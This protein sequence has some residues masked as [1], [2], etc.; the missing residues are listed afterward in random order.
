MSPC[1]PFAR[2]DS[3][4][5]QSHECKIVPLTSP[6]CWMWC[7][8]SFGSPEQEQIQG[9]AHGNTPGTAGCVPCSATAFSWLLTSPQTQLQSHP[10]LQTSKFPKSWL[11]LR[12]NHPKTT[13]TPQPRI[14]L[15]LGK[16]WGA[17]ALWNYLPP[18]VRLARITAPLFSAL[19]CLKKIT[20]WKF[21]PSRRETSSPVFQHLCLPSWAGNN[22][23]AFMVQYTHFSLKTYYVGA[24]EENKVRT[25]WAKCPLGNL[26]I[27]S[28][29]ILN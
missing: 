29:S 28:L 6:W 26:R 1:L 15:A 3:S 14:R 4:S 7:R 5:A 22:I 9:L 23:S 12:Q 21:V 13:T 27:K 10:Q 19:L 11:F 18:K 20:T 17:F 25:W 8:E 16:S 2:Q 24:L